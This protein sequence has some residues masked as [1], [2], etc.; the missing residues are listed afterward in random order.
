MI[1]S[2]LYIAPLILMCHGA[3]HENGDVAVDLPNSI[4]NVKIDPMQVDLPSSTTNNGH[5]VFRDEPNDEIG[6]YTRPDGIKV[7]L[8]PRHARDEK[9]ET[10][11]RETMTQ[12]ILRWIDTL[13]RDENKTTAYIDHIDHKK[14]LDVGI[15]EWGIFYVVFTV[16]LVL[17]N[18]ICTKTCMRFT[19][20]RK[21]F[22]MPLWTDLRRAHPFEDR[23]L[24]NVQKR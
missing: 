10:S 8:N 22:L 14:I 23:E 5:I 11:T 6:V 19:W 1:V 2:L 4:N 24:L 15:I 17:L 21:S 7:R 3:P 12:D 20:F 9:I 16:I 13:V 18:L